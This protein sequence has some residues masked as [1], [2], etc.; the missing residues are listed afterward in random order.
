MNKVLLLIVLLLQ[1]Y[2]IFA[3]VENRWS[4]FRSPVSIQGCTRIAGAFDINKA[5]KFGPDFV[6]NPV[7]TD[8]RFVYDARQEELDPT[9]WIQVCDP[10]GTETPPKYR[11]TFRFEGEKQ[12]NSINNWDIKKKKFIWMEE[13]KK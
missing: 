12:K 8:P 6:A 10:I 9:I 3:I 2:S 4:R 11:E 7:K 5:L 13:K 1:C